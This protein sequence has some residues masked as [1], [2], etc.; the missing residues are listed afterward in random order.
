M[1]CKKL[2]QSH[3]PELFIFLNQTTAVLCAGW[4]EVHITPL[5]IGFGTLSPPKF[6]LGH[7]TP[8]SLQNRTIN[9]LHPS[10]AVLTGGLADMDSGIDSVQY[11][12][13]WEKSERSVAAVMVYLADEGF[14]RA[15]EKKLS[16]DDGE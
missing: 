16:M 2:A 12:Q 3:K 4:K 15:M 6:G 10:R 8:L 5:T 11:Q 1:M 13:G 7:L 14:N 9:P